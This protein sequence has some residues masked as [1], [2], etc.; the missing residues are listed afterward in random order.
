M[1]WL[2][3]L[4][5]ATMTATVPEPS[6]ESKE[7]ILILKSEFKSMKTVLFT[8]V[9]V[10]E[11]ITTMKVLSKV[12][13]WFSAVWKNSGKFMNL[14]MNNWIWISFKSNWNN[15]MFRKARIYSLSLRDHEV[16]NKTFNELQKQNCIAWTV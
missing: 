10:Y 9:T 7:F 1:I 16:V 4:C 6:Y 13:D 5:C 11:D 15:K 8:D 3:H 12:V 2:C 14:F